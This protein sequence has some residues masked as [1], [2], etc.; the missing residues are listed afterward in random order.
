MAKERRNLCSLLGHL[1]NSGHRATGRHM[2]LLAQFY[3][4]LRERH[5]LYPAPHWHRYCSLRYRTI[6]GVQHLYHFKTWRLDR[7][8][9]DG[10]RKDVDVAA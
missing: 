5:K 9:S 3:R 7:D 2:L 4:H 6:G 1:S 8:M 10:V